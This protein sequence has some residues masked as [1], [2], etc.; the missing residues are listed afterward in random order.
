QAV[1]AEVTVNADTTNQ[2]VKITYTA[3]SHT[4]HINYVAK[5]GKV[6][7]TT[8]VTGA[9]DQTVKVPNET[10]A[11]WTITGDKVPSELTFNADGHVDVTIT[12]DHQH[13]TVTPDDPKTNGDRLPDNPTKTYPTGVGR[14]DLNKTITR[15]IKI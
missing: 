5:D 2:T 6:V 15:T 10:P 14:D 9:T 12:I 3:D 8:T 7:H 1:V 4:T 11:G 13:T